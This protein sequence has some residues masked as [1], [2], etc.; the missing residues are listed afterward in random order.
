M[1]TLTR[2]QRE[3]IEAST[4]RLQETTARLQTPSDEAPARLREIASA[5]PALEARILDGL[6]RGDDTTDLERQADALRAE[7]EA[8]EEDAARRRRRY[9]QT[10]HARQ[11][12]LAK[13]NREHERLRR[14]VYDD[15]AAPHAAA[16]HHLLTQVIEHMDAMRDLGLQT[17]VSDDRLRVTDAA[18]LAMRFDPD[19]QRESPHDWLLRF[20]GSRAA[21]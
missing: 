19:Y 7:R 21:A 9:E 3:R 13:A 10:E 15:A 2:E 18:A 6:G 8:I 20:R 11:Q 16:I 1:S 4:A 14:D 17:A 12:T 5:L